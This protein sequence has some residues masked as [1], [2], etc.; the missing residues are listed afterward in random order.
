M[1]QY[2]ENMS[3]RGMYDSP[4]PH[5]CHQRNLE[6]ESHNDTSQLAYLCKS[7]VKRQNLNQGIIVCQS[8]PFIKPDTPVLYQL[9]SEYLTIGRATK[10]PEI[11]SENII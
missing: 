6:M 7:R 11:H 5:Q 4:A 2:L 10:L 1:M 8:S 3:G 9:S